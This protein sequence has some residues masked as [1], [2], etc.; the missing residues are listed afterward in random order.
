MVTS[1]NK[2]DFVIT[3]PGSGKTFVMLL[4]INF[5]LNRGRPYDRCIIYS[6]EEIVVQ[7]IAEKVKLFS[8]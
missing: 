5:S 1:E 3:A 2:S 6:G 8:V 7:Q 4:A